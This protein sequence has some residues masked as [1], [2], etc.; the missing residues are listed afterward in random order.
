MAA[1][2]TKPSKKRLA[3]IA[4]KWAINPACIDSFDGLRRILRVF[5]RL[6]SAYLDKPGLENQYILVSFV[7]SPGRP[8]AKSSFV[9]L[10]W[11]T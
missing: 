9:Q 1:E 3:K 2:R 5:L 6:G 7:K 8:L 10:I 4:A 11:F